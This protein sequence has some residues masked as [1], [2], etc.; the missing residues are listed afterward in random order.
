[1]G[2]RS[3][4][5]VITVKVQ[6]DGE[7]QLK[8]VNENLKTLNKTVKDSSI[9]FESL[10]NK[11]L[12]LAATLGLGFGAK[13][14]MEMADSMSLLRD[15]TASMTGSAEIASVVIDRISEAANR[16]KTSIKDFALTFEKLTIATSNQKLTSSEVVKITEL[17][18]QTFKISGASA[19]QQTTSMNLLNRAFETGT[20]RGRDLRSLMVNNEY[21]F[22]LIA[23]SMG[24]AGV[25]NEQLLLK[26]IPVSDMLRIMSSNMGD[27]NRHANDLQ[28]TFGQTLTIAMNKLTVE[29]G[30][31]NDE[32]KLSSKFADF[33]SYIFEHGSDIAKA[34]GA[35]AAGIVVYKYALMGVEGVL[36]LINIELAGLP[37]L[38][39]LLV[40]GGVALAT[41]F[42]NFATKISNSLIG[43]KTYFNEAYL[44]FSNLRL[45]VAN[46]FGVGVGGIEKDIKSAREQLAKLKNEA[47]VS[48]LAAEEA[49]GKF[50]TPL[51]AGTPALDPSHYITPKPDYNPL[52]D[53]KDTKAEIGLLD[54]AFNLGYLTVET[55]NKSLENLTEHY[56]SVEQSIGKIS[57]AKLTEE[58]EKLNRSNVG[59]LFE[60]GK[61]TLNEYNVALKQLDLADITRK[62]NEGKVSVLAY[63]QALL[64][65]SDHFEGRSAAFVGIDNYIESSGTL[66]QNVAKNITLVFNTLEN[67]FTDFIKTGT[68]EFK[69]FAQ[70]VL[71]DLTRIIV[72]AAIIQPLA[73]GILGGL[74]FG[75]SSPTAN[76]SAD[77]AGGSSANLAANGFAPYGS[78]VSMFANGGVVSSPTM[79]KYG[80]GLNGVMGEAGPEAILP[81]TRGSNG[82]LGVSGGGTTVNIINNSGSEITQTQSTGADGSKVIDILIANKTKDL[83]ASGGMDKTMKLAY[84]LN[85]KGV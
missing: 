6:T 67:T 76:G 80:A 12:S 36:A 29:A 40:T 44:G 20:V 21:L 84:G 64:K 83:F 28:Q 9:S 15:R 45:S 62:F 10:K 71:D 61:L 79:F 49:R 31:L 14:L 2:L 26:G 1:M 27:I 11:F 63:N 3:Q 41:N 70:A 18:T 43:L 7:T 13:S 30:K 66:A 33:M 68:F 51:T 34:I 78:G 75:G 17:L 46:F 74:N 77:L 42:D 73:K 5:R 35:I 4:T 53:I 55:Y 22:R 24:K 37:L 16:T 47:D 54:E 38:L 81:L 72:R 85:R 52:K 57:F 32:F 58:M 56:L 82:K 59:R 25:S 19:Q 50:S 65:L 60:T 23:D 48:K 69:K 39:G 8:N